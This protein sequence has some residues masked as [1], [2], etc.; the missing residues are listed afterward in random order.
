[1]IC[2]RIIYRWQFSN[3]LELICLPT[4]KLFQVLLSNTNS[5]I[6]TQLNGFKYSKSLNSSLWPIYGTP[7]DTSTSGCDGPGSNGNEEVLYISQS[8]RTEALPSGGLVSYPGRLLVVGLPLCRDA[9]LDGWAIV[10]CVYCSR[11]AVCSSE[12][13]CFYYFIYN[14][15]Y[16]VKY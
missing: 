1:M 13:K 5:F 11:T 16:L 9:A 2:K 15:E 6:F 7:T 4:V 12:M 8:T 3:E 14:L 10:I